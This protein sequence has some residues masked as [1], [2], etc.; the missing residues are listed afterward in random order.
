[1]RGFRWFLPAHNGVGVLQR[2][3]SGGSGEGSGQGPGEIILINLLVKMAL[4]V[5]TVIE[6][7]KQGYFANYHTPKY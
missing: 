2:H 4:R 1:M 5:V 6:D 3:G 7:D